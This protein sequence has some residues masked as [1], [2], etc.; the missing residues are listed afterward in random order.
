[1]YDLSKA[2]AGVSRSA[3]SSVKLIHMDEAIK[4]L[5]HKQELHFELLCGSGNGKFDIICM[6][7]KLERNH[8]Q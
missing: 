3:C 8:E 2:K 1:M 4:K 6:K 5:L 7:K